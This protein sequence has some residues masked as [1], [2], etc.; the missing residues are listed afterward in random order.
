MGIVKVTWDKSFHLFCSCHQLVMQCSTFPAY[1]AIAQ[2][3][4]EIPKKFKGPWLKLGMA[5]RAKSSFHTSH[6]FCSD[7]MHSLMPSFGED[8]CLLKPTACFVM[9]LAPN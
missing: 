1:I 4:A 7:V 6:G 9:R 5:E 8:D 2:V 3:F